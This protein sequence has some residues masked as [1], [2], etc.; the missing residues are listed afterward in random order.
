M[1]VKMLGH[2]QCRA[3]FVQN[4]AVAGRLV[5]LQGQL[6]ALQQLIVMD[7]A[8][9]VIAQCA[10]LSTNFSN[11]AKAANGLAARLAS[12]AGQRFGDHHVH[13][14]FHWRTQRGDAQQDNLLANITNGDAIIVSQPRT[15]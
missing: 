6:P 3:A 13:F 1:F 10:L 7:E 8:A 4:A 12:G 2:A 5:N 15:S 9:P 11:A 14:R